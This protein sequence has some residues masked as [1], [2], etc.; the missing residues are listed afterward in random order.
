[1]INIISPLRLVKI[2]KKKLQLNSNKKAEIFYNVGFTIKVCFKEFT[3][4]P[5]YINKGIFQIHFLRTK[6]F[7]LAN[8]WVIDDWNILLKS[9]SRNF[10]WSRRVTLPQ[11]YTSFKGNRYEM[12]IQCENIKAWIASFHFGYFE[13]FLQLLSS[14]WV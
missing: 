10:Q 12:I 11:V 13:K 3:L 8:F 1:M 2:W 7:S 4:Y 6:S 9:L 14:L 5:E